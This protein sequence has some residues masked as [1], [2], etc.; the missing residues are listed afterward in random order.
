MEFYFFGWSPAR[1]RP[2][3]YRVRCGY[4]DSVM[5]TD[6][7]NK[8]AG[9]YTEEPFTL[10][11]LPDVGVAPALLPPQLKAAHF[12]S[13]LKTHQMTPEVDLLHLIE[14]LRR[15]PTSRFPDQPKTITVGGHAELTTVSAAGITQRILAEYDYA[16]GEP[17]PRAAPLDWKAWRRAAELKRKLSAPNNQ[18]AKAA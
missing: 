1:N 13:H 8:N 3:G 12:A 18:K 17:V 5:F 9:R 16:I 15:T 6:G 10:S 14:I 11:V 4:A 2:E 7:E